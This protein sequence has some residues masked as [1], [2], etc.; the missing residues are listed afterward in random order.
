MAVT[1]YYQTKYF[2][3]GPYFT[4][5][6]FNGVEGHRFKIGGRTSNKWNDKFRLYGHLLYHMQE[7]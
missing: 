7:H 5:Y 6:S 3:I 4:L 1:G 2:E